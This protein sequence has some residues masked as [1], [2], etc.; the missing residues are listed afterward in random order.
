MAMQENT[1]NAEIWMML[2]AM[3]TA[4]VPFTPRKAMY[5]TPTEK[6]MQNSHM[7]SGLLYVP[8]KVPGQNWLARYPAR[9]AVTPTMQPG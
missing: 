3:L 2:M 5:P 9:I 4:V 1:I 6:T 7:N 8:L